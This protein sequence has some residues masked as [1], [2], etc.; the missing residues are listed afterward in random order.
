VLDDWYFCSAMRL[1]PA[2]THDFLDILD[3]LRRRDAS[4]R[5]LVLIALEQLGR[6]ESSQLLYMAADIIGAGDAF[7]S[8][9]EV[10][11]AANSRMADAEHAVNLRISLPSLTSSTGATPI[12]DRIASIADVVAARDDAGRARS[13]RPYLDTI[14]FGTEVL[15]LAHLLSLSDSRPESI[16]LIAADDALTALLRRASRGEYG[17]LPALL[18]C[19]VLLRSDPDKVRL[20][21]ADPRL[22]IAWLEPDLLTAAANSWFGPHC[23]ESSGDVVAEVAEQAVLAS[24]VAKHTDPDPRQLVE[25]R[26]LIGAESGSVQQVSALLWQVALATEAVGAATTDNASW[27]CE[28]LS[29]PDLSAPVTPTTYPVLAGSPWLRRGDARWMAMAGRNAQETQRNSRFQSSADA[30]QFTYLL[31]STFVAV[32]LARIADVEVNRG[33]HGLEFMLH[34]ADV[35]ADARHRDMLREL[36]EGKPIPSD[37]QMSLPL[38]CLAVHARAVVERIGVCRER[39]VTPQRWVDLVMERHDNAPSTSEAGKLYDTAALMIATQWMFEAASGRTG[40]SDTDLSG[41]W[42]QSARPPARRALAWVVD[43]L[44]R[45][46]VGDKPTRVAGLLTRPQ[47]LLEQLWPGENTPKLTDWTVR[48]AGDSARI[49][50]P[51]FLLNPPLSINDW[52][53]L[54]EP[55][56]RHAG[57]YGAPLALDTERLAAL[58]PAPDAALGRLW[59]A[60][61]STRMDAIHQA[62]ELRRETRRRL[63]S[64][65]QLPVAHIEAQRLL[66][67]VLEKVIDVI[68]E[69]SGGA[70]GD[71]WALAQQLETD[72]SVGGE[73]IQML[74]LRFLRTACLIGAEPTILATLESPMKVLDGQHGTRAR[75]ATIRRFLYINGAT[76]VRT[77]SP[78]DSRLGGLYRQLWESQQSADSAPQVSVGL[79]GAGVTSVPD[80]RW[81]AAI[82]R[83]DSEQSADCRLLDRTLPADLSGVVDLVV[84]TDEARTRWLGELAADPVQVLGVVADVEQSADLP[85][86]TA[87]IN[88]GANVPVPVESPISCVVGEPVLIYLARNTAGQLAASRVQTLERAKP[89]PGEVRSATV[90]AR[91]GSAENGELA[92]AQVAGVRGDPGPESTSKDPVARRRRAMWTHRWDPDAS[93]AYRDGDEVRTLARWSTKEG[94]WLPIDRSITELVALLSVC[95]PED[96]AV[97]VTVVQVVEDGGSDRWRLSTEPG[98][99]Y[100][101]EAADWVQDDLALLEL[102]RR[103]S[104]VEGLRLKVALADLH[105]RVQIGFEG[106]DRIDRRNLEWAAVSDDSSESLV[107][108]VDASAGDWRMSVQVAG[109]ARKWLRV[110]GL[111]QYPGDRTGF[112]AESWD[113]IDQRTGTIAANPVDL[114]TLVNWNDPSDDDRITR[115]MTLGRDS[116]ITL[117]QM[118]GRAPKSGVWRARTV[119]GLVVEVEPESITMLPIKGEGESRL[120]RKRLAVVHD[121][122]SR[123][124]VDRHVAKPAPTEMLFSSCGPQLLEVLDRLATL[125]GLCAAR[126][127]TPGHANDPYTLWVLVADRPEVCVVPGSAF[128]V[129]PALVGDPVR[130]D[131]TVDGGW[132]VEAHPRTVRV[133]A[134]W[135]APDRRVA[136]QRPRHSYVC[137]IDDDRGGAVVSQQPRSADLTFSPPDGVRRSHLDPMTNY[138]GGRIRTDI[139]VVVRGSRVELLD[140]DGGGAV[141]GSTFGARKNTTYRVASARA[142]GERI[143]I[144]DGQEW[145]AFS[146]Q[147][148]LQPVQRAH[149]KED[150]QQ[151]Q[152]AWLQYLAGGDRHLLGSIDGDDVRL[153]T[154]QAPTPEGRWSDRVPLETDQQT[155]VDSQRYSRVDARVV[156]LERDGVWRASFAAT[157]PLDLTRFIDQLRQRGHA[158]HD[159]PTSLPFEL[160]YAGRADAAIPVHRF[161]WGYG[162]TL[163]IPEDRVEVNGRPVRSNFPMFYGDVVRRLAFPQRKDGRVLNLDSFSIEQEVASQIFR[164]ASTTQN[165]VHRVEVDVMLQSGTVRVRTVHGCRDQLED[166]AADDSIGLQVGNADLDD[167]SVRLL[168]QEEASDEGASGEVRRRHLLASLDRKEFLRT[169][170]RTIRFRRVTSLQKN[171]RV[172]MIAGEIIDIGN[173]LVLE[174]SLPPNLSG[175]KGQRSTA[176]VTRRAFSTRE[177]L[178]RRLHHTGASLRGSVLLV[179]LRETPTDRPWL[180]RTRN[181]LSRRTDHLLHYVRYHRGRCYAI[182]SRINRSGVGIEFRPGVYFW[183]PRERIWIEDEDDAVVEGSIIRLVDAGDGRLTVRCAALD[184]Q[185]YVPSAG[186]PAVVLPIQPLLK[187]KVPSAEAANDSMF[188]VAGLPNLQVTASD[189]DPVNLMR[190]SHPKVAVV[191]RRKNELVLVDESDGYE[192]GSVEF[193]RERS[194]PIFKPLRGKPGSQRVVGWAQLSFADEGGS[195]IAESFEGR[196]WL[197]HDRS[198]G[199]WPVVNNGIARFTPRRLGPEDAVT[200]ARGPVFFAPGTTLRYSTK[201]LRR[202]GFPASEAVSGIS[203]EIGHDQ[204]EY[205]VAAP[206]EGTVGGLWVETFPGRVLELSADLIVAG[207]ADRY[208]SLR[209]LDWSRFAPGDRVTLS[210]HQP[211]DDQTQVSCVAM[212][213]WIPGPRAAFAGNRTLLPVV[214]SQPKSMK[215][216][217]GRGRYKLSYPVTP[218]QLLKSADPR[219]GWLHADNTFTLRAK[220]D[221]PARDD[222]VLIACDRTDGALFVSG[223]R[224]WAVEINDDET[225]WPD[226]G[227]LQRALRDGGASRLLDMLNGAIPVTVDLVEER[228]VVVSRRLQPSGRVSPGRWVQCQIVGMIDESWVLLAAGGSLLRISA[229]DLVPGVPR[230][231]VRK[232]VEALMEGRRPKKWFRSDDAGELLSGLPENGRIGSDIAEIQVKPIRVLDDGA[233]NIGVLCLQIDT[234]THRW[235]PIGEF[236]W[237]RDLKADELAQV[238]NRQ[239][240]SMSCKVREDGSISITEARGG[241]HRFAALRPGSSFRVVVEFER[242]NTD[243]N[244]GSKRWIATVYQSEVIVEFESSSDEVSITGD[245]V[246]V[247][248]SSL[249]SAPHRHLLVVEQGRRRIRLDLPVQVIEAIR[250]PQGRNTRPT[251][252]PVDERLVDVLI[253]DKRDEMAAAL[254]EWL[255]ARGRAAFAL[256]EDCLDATALLAAAIVSSEAPPPTGEVT[257]LLHRLSVWLAWQCGTRAARS[258]HVE[259]IVASWI[260]HPERLAEGEWQRLSQIARDLNSDVTLA[261]AGEIATFGRGILGRSQVR[262]DPEL[263]AIARALLAAVGQGR[264]M[265]GPVNG[266]PTRLPALAAMGRSLVPPLGAAVSQSALLSG[267]VAILRS[268]FRDFAADGTILHLLPPALPW[269]DG[270][271]QLGEELYRLSLEALGRGARVPPV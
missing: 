97:W 271:L 35:L 101:A 31:A 198:T 63:V 12:T 100:L 14:E 153:S 107:A 185:A 108:A 41:R 186:R 59:F 118:L 257:P 194:V 249:V 74:Q 20:R 225:T 267:Q 240:Q 211:D 213:S 77:A 254:H 78:P 96:P 30:S 137:D 168:L 209:N 190:L 58:F 104:G 19:R 204:A 135:K 49:G 16:E 122:R 152:D 127:T 92:V 27:L 64:L 71:L 248:V 166:N 165:V 136:P 171:Q 129:L 11:L 223:L 44:L 70:P 98:I 210:L 83:D 29:A 124:R 169:M 184:D 255:E 228:R 121:V 85:F 173:D 172:F 270:R 176:R 87:W 91:H 206:V 263:T 32:K 180:A 141:H 61:W 130:V 199:H 119:D 241:A 159:R 243:T 88:C 205:V 75:L 265:P 195:R 146:R 181:G 132:T 242:A 57:D 7:A 224:G 251:R 90:K 111:D 50:A 25:I 114:H 197:Y 207:P 103:S 52:L 43:D 123:F 215:L 56:E 192:V 102:E 218:R 237:V 33:D 55:A 253:R 246:M 47:L 147:F 212:Y 13:E 170:G 163:E 68:V 247:E 232:V 120:G 113:A 109:V 230:S 233:G 45:R 138:T 178:L 23:G 36:T 174:L 73:F 196:R 4:E 48:L 162:W 216:V 269:P 183:V 18:S 139:D 157:A 236:G 17:R 268:T 221:T 226:C 193:D 66:R 155:W 93:A 38:A 151:Y 134:L 148:M 99:V 86:G 150:N 229:A 203:E 115:L 238:V 202:F 191:Q 60:S 182:L 244:G 261:T 5:D 67:L 81:V 80:E 28:W 260:R 131:R 105:G 54:S 34:V 133:R 161:E 126:P 264:S 175:W 256:D 95:E 239:S 2:A 128:T 231:A 144:G 140:P 46:S 82:F 266:V 164:E 9:P 142:Y 189:L 94:S 110:T 250:V 106:S 200:T 187:D 188:T 143:E 252:D 21:L 262:E 39:W 219:A 76:E 149:R 156:L 167:D 24:L 235:L 10:V 258:T 3:A 51:E 259:P 1:T 72:H 65:F 15:A 112:V 53:R 160:R 125:D 89:R 220:T 84:M 26:N 116:V 217:L 69:F 214:D 145:W 22:G 201:D 208:R 234:A 179:E 154:L 37:S 177:G 79:S 40:I 222:T 117:D 42:F 6:A 8:D 245:P 227:W 158:A 62:K